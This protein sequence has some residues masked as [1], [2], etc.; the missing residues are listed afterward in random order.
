MEISQT[1]HSPELGMQRPK[2]YGLQGAEPVWFMVF[3]VI[4]RHVGTVAAIVFFPLNLPLAV[5]CAVSYGVRIVGADAIYHRFFS[6]RT[7]R[8]GRITQF[9]LAVVGA[10]S[11]QRGPLWWAAKH[12]EHHKYAETERDPHSPTAHPVMYAAVRWFVDPEIGRAHV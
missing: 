11:G 1:G 3:R 10:Q 6:H 2:T 5:L 8:V 7:F 4:E 12:R 9:V